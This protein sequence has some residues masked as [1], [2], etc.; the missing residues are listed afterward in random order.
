VNDI[1]KAA[2]GIAEVTFEV[3]ARYSVPEAGVTLDRLAPERTKQ[4]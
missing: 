1:A 4:I 3:R 2:F